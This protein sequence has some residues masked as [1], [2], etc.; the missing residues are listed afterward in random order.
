MEKI[1]RGLYIIPVDVTLERTRGWKL[2]STKLIEWEYTQSVQWLHHFESG[3]ILGWSSSPV[4]QDSG[5]EAGWE[6]WSHIQAVIQRFWGEKW[7]GENNVLGWLIWQWVQEVSKNRSRKT[8]YFSQKGLI[9][10]L[11]EAIRIGWV[12][13]RLFQRELLWD[14]GQWLVIG[15]A[16]KHNYGHNY[17]LELLTVK[18]HPPQ[19][20]FLPAQALCRSQWGLLDSLSCH[21]CPC[22]A[23]RRTLPVRE[24]SILKFSVVIPAAGW[25]ST[26]GF[27]IARFFCKDTWSS[28]ITGSPKL[29]KSVSLSFI[30]WWEGTT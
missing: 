2:T 12:W 7:T 1:F 9:I 30:S 20:F 11:G 27:H 17:F 15:R 26:A 6:V 16:S 3:G 28:W 14:G 19:A 5:N 29:R 18:H 22:S 23:L 25:G 8:S 21:V 10:Y 24:W 4:Q 13:K